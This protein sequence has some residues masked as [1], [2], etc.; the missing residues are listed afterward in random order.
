MNYLWKLKQLKEATVCL[1][2]PV[3]LKF[4]DCLLHRCIVQAVLVTSMQLLLRTQSLESHLT[5]GNFYHHLMQI[6]M[7]VEGHTRQASIQLLIEGLGELVCGSESLY[8]KVIK[9]I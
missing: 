2:Q 6:L 5:L 1:N 3:C 8:S 9:F 7:V 4:M